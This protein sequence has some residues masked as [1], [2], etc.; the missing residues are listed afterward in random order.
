MSDKVPSKVAASRNRKLMAVQR[1]IARKKNAA[2]V[3]K[4]LEVLVEG[5]SE[6]HEFVMKGRHAGQ[7]PDI[8][9][10]VFLSGAEVHQGDVV[11]V[12]ITQTSDYDLVG[13]VIEGDAPRLAPPPKK[14][15]VSLKVVGA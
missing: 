13:E 4:E 11:R 3:G 5:P 6:E 8:D 10:E 14:K 1:K 9:G 12:E 2:K 15:K 7:A